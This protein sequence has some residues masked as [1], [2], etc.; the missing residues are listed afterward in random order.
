MHIYTREGDGGE[1]GLWGGQRV[2]KDDLRVEAYGTV[3]EANSVLGWCRAQPE[4]LPEVLELLA[5]VQSELLH[6]GADLASPEGPRSPA[7]P[8]VGPEAV[9][10]LKREIDKL[11]AE[12]PALRHFLLPSGTPAGAALHIART[13]TRRAER[14]VVALAQVEPVNPHV[15]AYLN[16]L[17]DLLFLLARRLTLATG[18]GEEPWIPRV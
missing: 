1:T 4:M 10:T 12:L 5:S 16:R 14:R 13:V 15:I 17:S 18:G 2:R 11:E 6:L 8:R 9:Q 3:D 7:L